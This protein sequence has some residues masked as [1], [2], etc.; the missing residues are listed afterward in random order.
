MSQDLEPKIKAA[1]DLEAKIKAATDRV[2][3]V[4][5]NGKTVVS[6]ENANELLRLLKAQMAQLDE[7]KKADVVNDVV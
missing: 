4:D 2:V 1:M 6:E 3:F 5:S 7:L